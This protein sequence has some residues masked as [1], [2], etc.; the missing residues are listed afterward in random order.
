MEFAAVVG[1]VGIDQWNDH[2]V[3]NT[4]KS[5]APV[6]ALAYK[7]K[8]EDRLTSLRGHKPLFVQGGPPRE[9]RVR[10]KLW[11]LTPRSAACMLPELAAR[12]MTEHRATAKRCQQESKGS[13]GRLGSQSQGRRAMYRSPRLGPL[14]QELYV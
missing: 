12:V 10:R 2:S 9:D 14:Q 11:A 5:E 13:D 8:P 1:S 6:M 7:G 4:Y 3:E